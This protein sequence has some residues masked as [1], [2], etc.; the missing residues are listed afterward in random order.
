MTYE[1]WRIVYQSCE[2]AA[3]AAYNAWEQRTKECDALISAC[4]VSTDIGLEVE[5][6]LKV[7]KS[8]LEAAD[9]H[10]AALEAEVDALRAAL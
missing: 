1:A 7:T 9:A 3:R 4:R 2:Q 6:E 8:K 5:A 10:I